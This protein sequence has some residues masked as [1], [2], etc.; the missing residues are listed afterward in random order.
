MMIRSAPKTAA[1]RHPMRVVTRRTGLSPD[2]LRVWE[3]RYNVVEPARS[4]SGRRL[5]SDADIERLQLLHRATLAGRS[6][7]QVA[8]LSAR[9]LADLVREDA[10]AEAQRAREGGRAPLPAALAP[11]ADD[12]PAHTFLNECFQAIEQLD[13]LALGLVLRRAV[14]ALPA[15]G[16]LDTLVVP[17]LERVGRA[18]RDG[19]LRSAHGQLAFVA[20]RRAL[21]GVADA[22]ASPLAAPHVIV[23]APAAPARDVT[24]R[25]IGAQE[26]GALLSA[27]TAAVEGWRVTYIGT[28]IPAEDIA[29]AARDTRA[30]AVA[31]SVASPAAGPDH[32]GD[33]AIAHEVSR[34]RALLPKGVDLVVGGAAA[35]AYRGVLEPN[36]PV[37]VSDL[38]GLRTQLR[39]MQRS[40]GGS[41]STPVRGPSPDAESARRASARRTRSARS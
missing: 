16:F 27:A 3:K 25:E 38:A 4:E 21:D 34:L 14:L 12:A 32:V 15:E 36:G 17:L 31:L 33:P 18:W 1:Q 30:R 39:A 20:L 5:Y 23:A 35:P 19:A 28:G 8:G 9:A 40:A 37:H 6:I 2:L 22:T 11:A 7:G 26:F 41:A 29:E 10:E 13:A 24:V